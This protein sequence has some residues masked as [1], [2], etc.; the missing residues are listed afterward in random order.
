[1]LP[2]I[3]YKCENCGKEFVTIP[4]PGVPDGMYLDGCRAIASHFFVLTV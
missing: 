2:K 4:I 3:H 1:M